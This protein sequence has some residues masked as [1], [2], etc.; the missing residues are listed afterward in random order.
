VGV[1]VQPLA[2]TGQKTG[3]DLDLESFATLADGSQ[4][5]NPRIFRVAEMSLKRAQRRVSRRE[6]GSHRRRKAVRLLAKAHQTVHR[7]SADFHH[8]TA[9]ALVRQYDTTYH[10]DGQPTNTVKNHHLAESMSDAGR[11]AFLSILSCKPVEAGKAV[12]AVPPAFTSQ[13]C[14]GCELWRADAQRLVRPLA[15]MSGVWSQSASGPEHCSQHLATRWT[16]QWGRAG[17]SG[18]NAARRGRRRLRSSRIHS[19]GVSIEG[20][21]YQ[22]VTRRS[23]T[24]QRTDL[25]ATR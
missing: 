21:P 6:Q 20:S 25:D 22:E 2:L 13:D 23:G 16:E 5:T 11:R 19:G 14:S 4:I 7:A 24:T 9:L 12:V 18:A 10:E 1:P 17:P 15:R 3:I 8:K